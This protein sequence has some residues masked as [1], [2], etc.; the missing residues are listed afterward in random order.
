MMA[1]SL[2]SANPLPDPMLAY[3]IFKNWEQIC[4][5]LEKKIVI[6]HENGFENILCKILSRPHCIIQMGG[7][8]R[9]PIIDHR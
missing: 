7:E 5:K 2:F 1:T 8:F 9:V 4:G 6:I 3:C